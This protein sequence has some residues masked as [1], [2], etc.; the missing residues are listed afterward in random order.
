MQT[1]IIKLLSYIVFLVPALS[2]IRL[3][4]FNHDERQKEDF[5][6]LATPAN[7][8]FLGFLQFAAEKI[9]VFY[10]YWVVIG[11]AIIFSLLLVSNI[12][13]FS[14]KFKTFK[15]KEN[16]P[17]YILLLLGAILL[18]AFQFGAFPVIILMYIL[19]SLS[20]LLVTKLHWL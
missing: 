19:I 20:H 7:A 17:R 1:P 16:I 4:K 12:P 2:A 14:L 3:A 8:L 18:I 9:P 13:M 11:T 10:N 15:I 6:G 5:I